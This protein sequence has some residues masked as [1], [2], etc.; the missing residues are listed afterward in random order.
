MASKRGAFP[1]MELSGIAEG[2]LYLWA[3]GFLY[4]FSCSWVGYFDGGGI[5]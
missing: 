1:H 2:V 5:S 3:E 4:L